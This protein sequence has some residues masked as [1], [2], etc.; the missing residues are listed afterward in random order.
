MVRL[1]KEALMLTDD[2][3]NGRAGYQIER[4]SQTRRGR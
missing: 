4:A 3:E 2:L 1:L